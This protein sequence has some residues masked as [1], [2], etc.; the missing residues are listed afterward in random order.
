LFPCSSSCCI[1]AALNVSAAARHTDILFC[2]S[3]C[4]TFAM[5]V[6]FPE[7]LIP[8]NRI[9]KGFFAELIFSMKFGGL[10][11]RDSI[12]DFSS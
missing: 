9:T 4:A 2:W 10:I 11:R 8:A 5:V 6:V 3:S 12:A 7:P 1:A